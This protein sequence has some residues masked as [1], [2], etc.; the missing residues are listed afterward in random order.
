MVVA[1][2]SA[3]NCRGRETEWVRTYFCLEI[4]EMKGEVIHEKQKK[5]SSN[6]VDVSGAFGMSGDCE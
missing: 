6:V 2:I 5:K 3:M 4:D 1:C